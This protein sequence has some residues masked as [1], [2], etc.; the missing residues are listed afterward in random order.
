MT[1]TSTGTSSD[2]LLGMM[3]FSIGLPLLVI[4]YIRRHVQYA[5][6]EFRPWAERLKAASTAV[7]GAA[8]CMLFIS[9]LVWTTFQDQAWLKLSVAFIFL[10]LLIIHASVE[11]VA[12]VA[13]ELD[14]PNLVSTT[15]LKTYLVHAALTC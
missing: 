15:S 13:P 11:A 14:R 10:G 4:W 9:P 12:R 2:A 8:L 3:I 6:D 7:L 1:V 5:R